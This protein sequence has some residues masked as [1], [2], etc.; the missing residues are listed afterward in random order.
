MIGFSTFFMTR[1]WK[2]TVLTNPL[3]GLAHDFILTPFCD[4]VNTELDTVTFSTPS[5]FSSFAKLPMLQMQS[6]SHNHM[7]YLLT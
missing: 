4:P 6:S 3:L 7:S 1:S 2:K 5:S